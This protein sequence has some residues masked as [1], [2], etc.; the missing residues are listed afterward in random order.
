MNKDDRRGAERYSPPKPVPATFG[1]FESKIVEISLIGCRIEHADRLPPRA[2]LSLRFAWRGAKVKLDA[3]VV[4]SELTSLRGK[5][6]YL[7]ALQFCD[8]PD[9]SPLVIRDVVGW[10][11]AAA[12]KG[13]APPEIVEQDDE[14]E[15]LSANYLRCT[16]SG[17]QWLK[18]FVDDPKQPGD[19]FTIRAP[20]DEREADLLC[21]AY[22][23]ANAA[24]RQ[25]MRASFQRD[26]ARNGR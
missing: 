22:E 1:G 23:T 14:P 17:G 18:L 15:L 2:R 19:G 26:I 21:R 7:S 3:T 20:A 24:K 16:L 5:P 11:A 6:S 8:S 4:R 9:A 10:L 13:E 25:T 12:K